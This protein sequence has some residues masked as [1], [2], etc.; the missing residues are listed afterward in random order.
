MASDIQSSIKDPDLL[1]LR[2]EVLCTAAARLFR[3][4]GYDRT[5][6]PDISEESGISVGSI[7]RY[8][9]KKEDLLYLML[10]RIAQ[11]LETDVYPIA[12][13]KSPA[14]TK[15]FAFMRAYYRLIDENSDHFYVALRDLALIGE[16]RQALRKQEKMT[17]V[18]FRD[19]LDEGIKGGQFQAVDS[20][21]LAHNLIC[22][23]HMWAIQSYK[24]DGQ[25]IED[26]TAR[27]Y[28]MV[29]RLVGRE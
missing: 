9:G 10:Q 28:A 26:Y 1:A 16:F 3:K 20:E 25:S 15:L 19:I 2:R 24:F 7:Y 14:S 12:E 27:Q 13:T 4:N 29:Q 11:R 17:Y 8:V 21:Y 23:G 22:I 5:S 18:C 6:I